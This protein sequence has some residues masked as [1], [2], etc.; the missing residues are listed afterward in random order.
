MSTRG[1]GYGLDAELAAKSAL[2][3]DTGK[4]GE[5]ARWLA[6]VTEVGFTESFAD[7]LKNGQMLCI[8]INRIKPGT[9][10]KVE[11]SKM[12]FKQ[13]ENISNFLK[14]CRV[15]GVA[16]HD[17]FETVDLFEQKDLGVVVNCIHALGRTVQTTVPE[18]RGPHLGVKMSGKSASSF[19]SAAP[20][21]SK[22]PAYNGMTK[23]AMGS[24]AT[25]QR[26]TFND[27]RNVAFGANTVGTGAT[28]IVSQQSMGSS[29]TMQRSDITTSNSVTFGA[30]SASGKSALPP[31]VPAKKKWAP[32][33][34][35]RSSVPPPAPSSSYSSSSSYAPSA[36]GGGYGL[37]AELAKKMALKYDPKLEAEAQQWV[38]QVIGSSF[39]TSFAE[40]LKNGQILCT[41]INTI[42]PGTI[43]SVSTSKMPFKQVRAS[44]EAH[45]CLDIYARRHHFYHKR[46][47]FH[48]FNSNTLVDARRW[49]TS[50]TTSK[51]AGPSASP[52]TTS[53]RQSTSTSRRTWAWSS[54][55]S[56]PW[57][58][59]SRGR[60]P[61]RSS[62]PRWR[63]RTL[64]SSLPTSSRG[65]E[66]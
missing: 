66:A 12:P 8:L 43:R 57:G 44:E 51:P 37:D 5:A 24:S 20:A 11:T 64:G 65:T 32:A 55:A 33:P 23:L 35:P 21:P 40:S 28:N 4:E 41:L 46:I 3:Y 7:S 10:K 1:A 13:M 39:P 34:A 36:R 15:L 61:G 47:R 14:A 60:T 48:N 22:A 63:T 26:S 49:K 27:T 54:P 52:S 56:T 30:D 53:S 45:L 2:K 9:I 58:G 42:K 59:R 25:M 29:S 18:F 31:A 50:P 17:L 38:E 16:E 62:G 19:R 6:E